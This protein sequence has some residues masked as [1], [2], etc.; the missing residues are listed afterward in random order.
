MDRESHG[1]LGPDIVQIERLLERV[2]ED[3]LLE[4]SSS[5]ARL[6]RMV[7]TGETELRTIATGETEYVFKVPVTEPLLQAEYKVSFAGIAEKRED[8]GHWPGEE[9]D[10]LKEPA[11]KLLAERTYDEDETI[12]CTNCR[13]A[14][15]FQVKCMC[16]EGGIVFRDMETGESDQLRERG[17]PDADCDSCNGTGERCSNCPMC[18][19]QGFNYLYPRLTLVNEATGASKTVVLDA[20]QLLSTGELP[21]LSTPHALVIKITSLKLVVAREL[22]LD[23]DTV[24]GTADSYGLYEI[25]DPRSEI[26]IYRKNVEQMTAGETIKHIQQELARKY[27]HDFSSEHD[28][29]GAVRGQ[30]VRLKQGEPLRESFERLIALAESHGYKIGYRRGFLETGTTGPTIVLLDQNGQPVDELS[31]D[32]H[33]SVAVQDALVRLSAGLQNGR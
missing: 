15:T 9:S 31:S 22:G 17:Q 30:I 24:Y 29:R 23:P 5:D 12:T 1:E 16:T 33:L 18:R 28:E 14:C 27:S 25:D 6:F 11:R 13:G 20:A 32:Y 2:T 4:I 26:Y 3:E 10:E 8:K 19:A 21:V 7:E